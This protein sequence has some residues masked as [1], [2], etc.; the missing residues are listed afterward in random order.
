MKEQEHLV[1]E[2]IDA[3]VE[4]IG[5]LGSSQKGVDLTNWFNLLTFDIIGELAFGESFDGVKSGKSSGR[6]SFP[7]SST[8]MHY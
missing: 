2:V 8:L 1:A 5:K 3:F 7:D 4:Q 6:P